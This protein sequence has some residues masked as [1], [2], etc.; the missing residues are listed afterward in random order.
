MPSHEFSTP[1]SCPLS[2]H[3][4]ATAGAQRSELSRLVWGQLGTRAVTERRHPCD[5]LPGYPNTFQPAGERPCRQNTPQLCLAEHQLMGEK[6]SDRMGRNGALREREAPGRGNQG[7][8]P[9]GGRQRIGWVHQDT[10][11]G[12]RLQRWTGPGRRLYSVGLHF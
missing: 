2:G 3:R 8:L 6:S 12:E 5:P 11:T 4:W 9:G 7:R 1:A 10:T